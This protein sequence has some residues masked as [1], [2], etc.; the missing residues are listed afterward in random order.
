MDLNIKQNEPL[1]LHTTFKAG[2]EA[3]FFVEVFS[4]EELAGAVEYAN[5]NDL[6]I[7]PLGG[8]S[9]TLF[10]DGIHNGS[11]IKVSIGGI[12]EKDL[13]GSVEIT[14]GAGVI[15]DELVSFS[16]EKGLWG[17]ENLSCIPGF[18]G[19]ACVQNIGAYGSELKDTL[20]EVF[21][22]DL[23]NKTFLNI[24]KEECNYGYRESLFKNKKRYLI[25]LAT[26][27][28]KKKSNLQISY[29]D[30]KN[31][32]TEKI[33]ETSSE[34]REAVISIRGKKFP[35]LNKYGTAGSF[36]KNPV[37]NMDFYEKLLK[38]F[39]EIPAHSVDSKM[40]LSAAWILDKALNLKGYAEGEIS[41]WKE[42]PLV[43]VNAGSKKAEDIILFVEKIKKIVFEKIGINLE[44]EVVII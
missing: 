25:V 33:P 1:S 13:G 5:K 9:N 31:Y 37:I 2:G 22:F 19:G 42:Q 23:E 14:A 36:F 16:T 3:L 21:V 8:G 43:V 15:W 28:L 41:L 26:F 11:V 7:I 6:E 17:L 34:V 40:K 29:K 32:F 20:K 38:E 4:K 27:L 35:D 30:L 44:E 10:K 18:V 24:K 39:P 12:E